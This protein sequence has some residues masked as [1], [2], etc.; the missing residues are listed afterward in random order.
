MSNTGL[1]T[2]QQLKG[3]N[4]ITS[5][6]LKGHLTFSSRHNLLFYLHIQAAALVG[7]AQETVFVANSLSNKGIAK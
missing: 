2:E 7:T 6:D 1:M 5:E 4:V 3:R